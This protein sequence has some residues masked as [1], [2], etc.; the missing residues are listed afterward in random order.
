MKRRLLFCLCLIFLCVI[1]SNH[2]S[3]AAESNSPDARIAVINNEKQYSS[4]FKATVQALF[5][6]D[7]L[8]NSQVYLSYHVYDTSNN[9][10]KF[11]GER[12]A[13]KLISNNLYYAEFNIDLGEL[14]SNID[15]LKLTFDLVD[16]KNAYWYSAN[17]GIV[18]LTD[19]IEYE[20]NL[21]KK[22]Q[23]VL[24]QKIQGNK[25]LFFLGVLFYLVMAI[26]LVVMKKFTRLSVLVRQAKRIVSTRLGRLIGITLF[27]CV[28]W[29]IYTIISMS[30]QLHSDA[31]AG[32]ISAMDVAKGN[33]FLS[34][35]AFNTGFLYT[36]EVP[37]NAIISLFVK[38]MALGTYLGFGFIYAMMVMTAL[39]VGGR[40]EQGFSILRAFVVFALIGLPSVTLVSTSLNVTAHLGSLAY[41]LLVFYLIQ[42]GKIRLSFLIM[43]LSFFGDDFSIYVTG[44]P[45]VLAC[46]LKW[47]EVY[48]RRII[49][50]SFVAYLTSRG[51]LKLIELLG[52]TVDGSL[53]IGNMFAEQDVVLSNTGSTLIGI[54]NLFGANFFG[55]YFSDTSTI[56]ILLH[57]LGVCAVGFAVFRG[58]KYYKNQDFINTTLIIAIIFIILVRTITPFGQLESTVRYMVL[59]VFYGAV[60][61]ARSFD[62]ESLFHQFI[63]R[64]D[65]KESYMK[66]SK[67]VIV[68]LCSIY[69]LSFS[70]GIDMNPRM[71][72]SAQKNIAHFLEQNN[73][74]KGLADYWSANI[75]TTYSNDKVKV[76]AIYEAADSIYPFKYISKEEWFQDSFEFILINKPMNPFKEE[77]LKKIFGTPSSILQ[78]QDYKIYLFNS[79]ITVPNQEVIFG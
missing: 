59:I 35:W 13:L 63:K 36:T 61:L 7:N 69:F 72:D 8:Y 66:F 16:E 74:Q 78:F 43:T 22:G 32:Y 6:K 5:L 31:V 37:W 20:H 75:V 40:K 50:M 62:F 68:G 79:P 4:Q 52:C 71:A 33:I 23:T 38:N 9:L 73:L 77:T 29:T 70:F 3:F 65:T 1:C 48:Y 15:N 76:R 57:V 67:P 58:I 12:L 30:T 19:S 14:T 53:R 28:I 60:L 27:F 54:L 11:E 46:L 51:L 56:A 42:N 39:F 49:I 17:K 45:I 44:L 10:I 21:L 34:G 2:F 25:L 24:L 55:H 41:M 47:R 64:I 18:L 26:L